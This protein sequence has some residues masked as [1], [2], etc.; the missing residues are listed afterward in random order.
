M[1]VGADKIDDKQTASLSGEI[2]KKIQ[3]EMTYQMCIRDR[4]WAIPIYRIAVGGMVMFGALAS[5]ELAWSL[6]EDVYKRQ[7]WSNAVDSKAE[8]TSGLLSIFLMRCV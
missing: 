8:Q 3:D 5:L 1:I 7:K 2:A 6:A 4:K